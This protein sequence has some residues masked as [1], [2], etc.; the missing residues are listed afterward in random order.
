VSRWAQRLPLYCTRLRSECAI[1]SCTAGCCATQDATAGTT[2]TDNGGAVC[3]GTGKCVSCL[4]P[5]DCPAPTTVCKTN[6][7]AADTCGTNNVTAGAPCAEGSGVVCDGHGACVA[8]HCTDGV[9]DADETD[10]DCG[11]ASCGKC[12]ATLHCDVAGDCLDGV[13]NAGGSD[14]GGP[15][16][17]QAPTC[18][19]GVK[20]GNETDTDC[21][22]SALVFD[23][24]SDPA[25]PKCADKLHCALDTDCTNNQCFGSNPGT[26]VSCHDGVKDGNET[27]QDCGGSDCDGQGLT[28]ATGLG[29]GAPADC[30]SGVC[31]SSVCATL[32]DGTA[33][34]GSPQCTNG[35]CIGPA[36]SQICC[37]TACTG[38]CQACTMALTGAADGTCA[39]ITAG[40]AAPTGQ[41]SVTTTCGND[42][43]CA[44]GG[45]C[46]QAANTVSCQSASCNN[47]QIIAAASC[48][49]TGTC[50]TVSA[51]ACPGGF[52]CASAT[53]C[54]TACASNT[55]CQGTGVFCQN[56]GAS[57][58]CVALLAAGAVCANNSQCSSNTCGTSGTGTHCCTAACSPSGGTCGASDCDATGACVFPGNS[59]SCGAS[60]CSGTTFTLPSACNG[61]GTCTVGTLNCS[62][63][64][65][66]CNA[67]AGCV[68]C[69]TANDCAA[70]CSNGQI[71]AATCGA[72]TCGVGT[73]AAGPGGFV[74]ASATACKTACGSDTDCQ[75]P[76][77]FCQNPG[78]SGTCV[79]LLA[80]GAVCS[81]STQCSSNTCGTSGTGTHCCTAACNPS[82]G[83]CGA[84]DC[85]AT[86]ACVFPGNTVAPAALQTPDD[87]QKV[88]CNGAG[89][90]TSIDDGSDVP[91]V[92]CQ[93][94]NGTPLAP[95]PLPTGTTCTLASDASAHVCGDTSN[96]AI[97][98]TCV[99]CN[100]ST[101]CAAASCDGTGTVFTTAATCNGSN[102]CVAGTPTTCTG[103]T[104][105]C[106]T[107]GCSSTGASFDGD[108][109]A[110]PATLDPEADLNASTR[111]AAPNT[112]LV[113]SV[114]LMPHNAV[115]SVT[116]NYTIDNFTT[117]I[118]VTCTRSGSVGADDTWV[119]TIPGQAAGKTVRFYYDAKPYTGNDIFLPGSNVNY[120]F[121]TQ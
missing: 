40:T 11:G 68:Q 120:T 8:V 50:P 80:A 75:G 17:C 116:L 7:C 89:G 44:A 42:G 66:V 48:S 98:G 15:T 35:N 57:G 28:C 64:T 53:A 99:E 109:T 106:T 92:A 19:D 21:G 41:C 20:N 65:P 16:T 95:T 85:D 108:A 83:P 5:T 76:G 22:G 39:N 78:N 73:A 77:V 46:E 74:C 79:A 60:S 34:T 25:C 26:C 62:G 103:T 49:G 4:K 6:T 119:A 87:C 32:P 105:F 84:T 59:I 30:A 33:C 3:D 23:G 67:T 38:T 51:T 91:Q 56:P 61:A 70:A 69:N 58:T 96:N 81:A 52:V 55:D 117:T 18:S 82:G 93:N 24:G 72:N 110:P 102:T 118:P 54:K 90:F 31:Q 107:S 2:C 37:H 94:C 112:A 12:A 36:G 71:A 14:G 63:P 9:K 111:S 86:G 47:G 10:T 115:A 45:A 97:M 88:V 1:P 121:V 113:V 29:C 101:D 100:V 27:G 13:C 114:S 104:S 43:K